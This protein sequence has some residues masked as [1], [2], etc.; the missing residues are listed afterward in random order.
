MPR[1]SSYTVIFRQG[2]PNRVRWRQ[3]L[4]EGSRDQARAQAEEIE[5]GGRRALVVT[6]D[7]LLTKGLPF[8][9]TAKDREEDFELHSDGF[10]WRKSQ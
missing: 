1:K 6:V 7:D 3:L 4:W 2:G 5:R 10:W 9:W 8:G